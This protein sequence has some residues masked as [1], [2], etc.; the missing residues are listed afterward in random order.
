MALFSIKQRFVYSYNLIKNLFE[1]EEVETRDLDFSFL[2]P[3]PG[4]FVYCFNFP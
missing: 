2:F 4:L 1:E 3:Q